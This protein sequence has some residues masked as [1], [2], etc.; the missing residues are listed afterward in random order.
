LLDRGYNPAVA[1]TL[2]FEGTG[3]NEADW[4]ARLDEPLA[5]LLGRR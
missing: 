1:S 5:F 4:A 2:V 3:H